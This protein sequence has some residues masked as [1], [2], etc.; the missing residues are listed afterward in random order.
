MNI[1]HSSRSDDWGTPKGIVDSARLV[2]GGRIDI[3]PA[4]SAHWNRTVGA[5]TYY[6]KDIDGITKDWVGSVY[7]NPPGGKLGNKSNT[8][9]FWGKLMEEVSLGHVE[10][11]IFMAFSVEALAVTQE[12]PYKS[13][14]EFMVCIPSKRIK[15]DRPEGVLNT[16]APSHSNA[17]VYVP[18]STNKYLSFIEQFEPFGVIL[19]RSIYV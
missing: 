19:N 18:G 5:V 15:F 12:K 9:R 7:C 8:A 6:S 11:A 4:S 16:K 14:G 17:I 1:Q 10:H 13:M 2:L 3:D